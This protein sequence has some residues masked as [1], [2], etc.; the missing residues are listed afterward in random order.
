[1]T[2]QKLWTS[3]AAVVAIAAASLGILVTPAM[4]STTDSCVELGPGPIGAQSCFATTSDSR[5]DFAQVR[6][7]R[8]SVGSYTLTCSQSRQTFTK[9]GNVPLGGSRSFF[10]QGLFG[11]RD[12]DCT[13]SVRATNRIANRRASATVTLVS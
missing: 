1:M 2:A 12:P 5:V 3:L 7:G 10:T 11:L 4:A 13:I 8:Y 9:Q 6:V